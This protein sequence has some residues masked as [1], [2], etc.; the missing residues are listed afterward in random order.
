MSKHTLIPQHSIRVSALL[1]MMTLLSG[2]AQTAPLAQAAEMQSAS[3]NPVASEQLIKLP[4][5]YL[6][7]RIDADF[8]KSGLAAALSE[9]AQQV[10]LKRQTLGDLQAASDRASGELRIDLRHQFLAEKQA[11]IELMKE[12]QTLRRSRTETRVRLYQSLLRRLDRKK[13]AM[14]PQRVALLKKQEVAHS[15]FEASRAAVDTKLFE[16]TMT[17]ESRY[18]REYAK[19]LSAIEQLVAAVQTHP[20]NA[21][22]SIDGEIIGTPEYLQ[23][24]VTDGEAQ[25]AV[26]E[27]EGSILGYMAKLVSLDALALSETLSESET[28][29]DQASAAQPKQGVTADVQFFVSR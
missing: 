5:Q 24:L 15:R 18:A 1:M 10:D 20:M 4:P 12:Q 3:W 13:G 17:T 2:T 21:Q 7:K 29:I 28:S 11:Y 9:K 14:T 16:T 19:N 26:I 8:S 6:Q 23:R 22:P 25:L 27:Q